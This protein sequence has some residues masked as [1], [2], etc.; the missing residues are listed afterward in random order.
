MDSGTNQGSEHM[1]SWMR[2]LK[3]SQERRKDEKIRKYNDV[4]SKLIIILIGV[5]IVCVIVI[6]ALIVQNEGL[7][8]SYD[9]V[10]LANQTNFEDQLG[11]ISYLQAEN[12]KYRDYIFYNRTPNIEH[13]VYIDPNNPKITKIIYNNNYAMLYFED[14][15]YKTVN[16]QDYAMVV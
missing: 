14:G 8:K 6:A 16:F 2:K 5:C 1:H 10:V 7:K 12:K 15:T 13:T 9:Q 11:Q 3:E 4:V